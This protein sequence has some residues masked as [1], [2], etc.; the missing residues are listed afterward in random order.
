M[1][2]RRHMEANNYSDRFRCTISAPWKLHARHKDITCCQQA[3]S[4][5]FWQWTQ[6]CSERL[7]KCSAEFMIETF[8]NILYLSYANIRFQPRR[9]EA[10]QTSSTTR[11]LPCTAT[12]LS[13]SHCRAK[14]KFLPVAFWGKYW[15]FNRK[16]CEKFK[17]RIAHANRK[18]K[19]KIDDGLKLLQPL[20]HCLPNPN[21]WLTWKHPTHIN[22]FQHCLSSYSFLQRQLQEKRKS[23][24]SRKLGSAESTAREWLGTGT[25]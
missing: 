2:R 5:Q 6:F 4:K 3:T 10:L 21:L 11:R 13:L 24:Q 18:Q 7:C 17:L 9:F 22:F 25:R 12:R 1:Q 16:R 15:I 19:P 20:R 23:L 14:R 8:V